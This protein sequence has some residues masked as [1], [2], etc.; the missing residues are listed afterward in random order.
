MKRPK[1]PNDGAHWA[2]RVDRQMNTPRRGLTASIE[3]RDQVMSAG[4]VRE[5]PGVA[6]S[7]DDRLQLSSV[8]ADSAR[9]T[10]PQSSP[11]GQTT[12]GA[13]CSPAGGW[14]ARFLK[15]LTPQPRT[16]RV[17][18]CCASYR[19]AESLLKQGWTIAPEEDA[20]RSIGFVFLE[21][22][23]EVQR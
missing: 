15:L 19:E 7:N 1:H 8:A 3:A 2:D 9:G 13:G 11:Q 22:L 21:K 20:N 5:T 23:E 14:L 16:V 17:A 10:A 6:A 12:A 4:H 18:L